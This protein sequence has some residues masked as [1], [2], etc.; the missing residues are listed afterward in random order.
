HVDPRANFGETS[1][2]NLARRCWPCH[3]RKTEE[4]RRRGLLGKHAPRRRK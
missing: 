3:A 1:Y 2:R 4:D